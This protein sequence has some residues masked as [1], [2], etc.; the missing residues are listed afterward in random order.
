MTIQE[1]HKEIRDIMLRVAEGK[2]DEVAAAIA[3]MELQKSIIAVYE[4]ER[5]AA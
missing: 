1:M 2:Q 3:I 5:K 4:N